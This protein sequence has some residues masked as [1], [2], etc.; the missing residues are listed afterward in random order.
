MSNYNSELKKLE[1]IRNLKDKVIKYHY[2][3]LLK[4]ENKTL[5]QIHKQDN[6]EQQFLE[7]K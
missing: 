2:P 6:K 1:K 5:N 3:F 7:V 4:M